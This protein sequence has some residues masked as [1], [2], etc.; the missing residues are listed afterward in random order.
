[1]VYGNVF[2]ETTDCG[3]HLG[4][5]IGAK[6]NSR[7]I[8]DGINKFLIYFNTI[9]SLFPKA[10]TNVKYTLFQ[11]YWIFPVMICNNFISYVLQ[12]NLLAINVSIFLKSITYYLFQTIYF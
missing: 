7:A 12:L 6:G 11:S 4:H 10:H 2:I 3:I 8:S 1:M 9:M 5:P